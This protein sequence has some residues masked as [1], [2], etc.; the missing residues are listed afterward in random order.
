MKGKRERDD[1]DD[2]PKPMFGLLMG[3]RERPT[4]SLSKTAVTKLNEHNYES[5]IQGRN[6]EQ[7]SGSSQNLGSSS[8]SSHQAPSSV[9]GRAVS[10][11]SAI[12][13]TSAPSRNTTA[14]QCPVNITGNVPTIKLSPG[15]GA[16]SAFQ[17]TFYRMNADT[18]NESLHHCKRKLSLCKLH[19]STSTVSDILNRISPH[20]VS[21]VFNQVHIKPRG[22]LLL[23]CL[24]QLLHIKVLVFSTR[25]HPIVITPASGN[26]EH[27]MAL[28]VHNDSYMQTTT[29]YSLKH[30]AKLV[31]G[32]LTIALPE[33]LIVAT[34]QRQDEQPSSSSSTSQRIG[35]TYD[36][37][38]QS[39]LCLSCFSIFRQK[40]SDFISSNS[41][42]TAAE[43][44]Q[45][46]NVKSFPNGVVA[47]CQTL[48]ETQMRQDD[49][50]LPKGTNWVTIKLTNWKKRKKNQF[51]IALLVDEFTEIITKELASN[52]A[53][54]DEDDANA[55]EN[56]ANALEDDDNA[57]IYEEEEG[58]LVHTKE[59]RMISR[60][61]KSVAKAQSNYETLLVR[62]KN[63]KN[64]CHQAIYGLSQ[65]ISA[66]AD[67]VVASECNTGAH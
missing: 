20:D 40:W 10:S 63:L 47:A 60:T 25:K 9:Q 48:V 17:E 55:D 19:V 54:A 31:A 35:A 52:D 26:T 36:P 30:N 28:L 15:Q 24:C 6:S 43:F 13:S 64:S 39:T 3:K 33:V 16:E 57:S 38:I 11:G 41:L 56:D 18:F 34:K 21:I 59:Y 1:Q 61:L 7:A 51:S 2:D 14:I 44:K 12:Q 8:S 58:Q 42:G 67:M 5:Q 32:S 65:C 27:V 4:L 37:L 53:N 45:T 22:Y 29:W 62:M 50:V 46:I 23:Y 66:L 49:Q